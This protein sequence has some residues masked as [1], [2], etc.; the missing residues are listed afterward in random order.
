MTTP[1]E[2]RS[3]KKFETASS[4]E[5]SVR[6]ESCSQEECTVV[7]ATVNGR[8]Q[9]HFLEQTQIPLC[10]P[11][12]KGEFPPWSSNPSFSKRGKGRFFAK[13]S[14]KLYS[15]LLGHHTRRNSTANHF[16]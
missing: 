14:R 5:G 9:L 12:L 3:I 13:A 8:S 10:P 15:E 7:Y 6:N 2:P 1:G 4:A 16:A 11:L